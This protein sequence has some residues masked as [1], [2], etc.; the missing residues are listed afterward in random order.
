MLGYRNEM[1]LIK[2][3]DEINHAGKLTGVGHV[4]KSLKHYQYNITKNIF[5]P[6]DN[7]LL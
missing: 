4:V 7:F 3:T 2:F 1:F 6:V 5:N